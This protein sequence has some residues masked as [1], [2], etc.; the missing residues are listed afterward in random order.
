MNMKKG[1]TLI[2][3]LA[4]IVILAIIALIATPIILDIINDAREESNE[5]S[6]E[7][8]GTAIKNAIANS[9]LNGTQIASGDLSSTFLST[10]QYDGSRVSCTTNKLY[11]DGNIYLAGC[12]V[13]DKGNY[14][15]GTE[16]VVEPNITVTASTASTK[17]TGNV[18]AGEYAAGDEYIINI[19]GADRIFFVLGENESDTS[20][21]DLIMN[22]NIGNEVEW[23]TDAD[24]AAAGGVV[25]NEMLHDNGPCE[26]YE[27]CVT[28]EYG[29]ITANAYLASQ[30]STWEVTPYLPTKEQIEGAY[31]GSIPTW[32][33]DYLDESTHS[34]PDLYGYWTSS[35]SSDDS[36]GVWYVHID[37]SVRDDIYVNDHYTGVRPV[38]TI[39]KSLLD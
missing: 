4:V 35:P 34:V 28:N 30:T 39:S 37:G 14:T 19:G 9:E 32:L 8:Y 21:V 38:I 33:Y 5:R 1:F 12:T 10:V 20:K 26:Y 29:P 36:S 6:V 11:S 13:N 23:I 3:L 2:E 7:L 22:Q 24:W 31:T 16:Q 15:Y 25:T 18:P 17:T 27:T